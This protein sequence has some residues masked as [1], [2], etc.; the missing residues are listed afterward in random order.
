MLLWLLLLLLSLQLVS[1]YV[2]MPR[3]ALTSYLKRRRLVQRAH[4]HRGL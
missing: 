2:L 4:D 1:I 3:G